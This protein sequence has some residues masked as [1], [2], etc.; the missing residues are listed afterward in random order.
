ML[1]T[2][3]SVTALILNHPPSPNHGSVPAVTFNQYNSETINLPFNA[4]GTG[5]CLYQMATPGA[6][7]GGG[8]RAGGASPLGTVNYG[9]TRGDMEGNE[10]FIGP[11]APHAAST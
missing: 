11:R 2:S 9:L 1:I 7:T 5:R 4:R 3:Y 8:F 10:T 6:R